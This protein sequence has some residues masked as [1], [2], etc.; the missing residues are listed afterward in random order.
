[1]NGVDGNV[2]LTNSD[3]KF[4]PISEVQ[5]IWQH[6]AV[7]NSLF[8]AILSCLDSFSPT[9]NPTK[10]PSKSP[11]TT[12]TK[13]AIYPTQSPMAK[14]TESAITTL[15]IF[16]RNGESKKDQLAIYD[17]TGY[18]VVALIVTLPIFCVLT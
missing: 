4:P 13:L 2:L 8:S 10:N 17:A 16:E 9:S 14:D 1:M 15:F 18:V 7:S 3:N 11:L 6:S 5:S 12:T